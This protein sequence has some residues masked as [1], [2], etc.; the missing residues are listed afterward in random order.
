MRLD[1]LL[2]KEHVHRLSVYSKIHGAKSLPACSGWTTLMGGTLTLMPDEIRR[3][4][5]ALSGVG[6]VRLV[7]AGMSTLLGPEGPEL[8]WPTGRGWTDS[9]GPF[10]VGITGRQGWVPPVL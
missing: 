2:S 7:G 5:Y 4:Q 1:H 10:P 6:T 9:S 3:I 8:P